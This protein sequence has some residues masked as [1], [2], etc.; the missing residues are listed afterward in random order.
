MHTHAYGPCGRPAHSLTTLNRCVD[1]TKQRK[2]KNV[3]TNLAFLHLGN[4]CCCCLVG[5]LVAAA[6]V[7]IRCCCTE[8]MYLYE[9]RVIEAFIALHL[10]FFASVAVDASEQASVCVNDSVHSFISAG[11]K[12]NAFLLRILRLRPHICMMGHRECMRVHWL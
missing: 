1:E 7:G 5:W 9:V 11:G 2:I 12:P 6:A 8:I 4:F 3:Y 10:Y